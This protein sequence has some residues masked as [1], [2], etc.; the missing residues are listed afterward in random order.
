MINLITSVRD[1]LKRKE[2]IKI[3]TIE[4]PFEYKKL[5]GRIVEKYGTQGEFAK[6]IGLSENSLSKKMTCVTGL[7]QDDI[8]LWSELLDIPKSDFGD[9]F[10][11]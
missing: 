2:V 10:Y 8:V 3:K 7:S 11:T 5:R 4:R 9:F 1:K 6:A